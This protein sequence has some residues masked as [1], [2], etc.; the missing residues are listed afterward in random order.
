MKRVR[1]VSQADAQR[2]VD[3]VDVLSHAGGEHRLRDDFQGQLHHLDCDVD[4][5]PWRLAHSSQAV[6]A[7]L[8]IRS[9][10]AAIRER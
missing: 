6:F 9:A 5:R 2:L 10:M 1:S 4:R 3:P 8:T 7:H